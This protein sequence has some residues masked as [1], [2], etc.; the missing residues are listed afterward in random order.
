MTPWLVLPTLIERQPFP[1]RKATRPTLACARPWNVLPAV[2]LPKGNVT[3]N[4]DP[5]NGALLSSLD[6]ALRQ[7]GV[8]TLLDLHAQVVTMLNICVL[9]L[10]LLDISSAFYARWCDTFLLTL[11]KFSLEHHSSPALSL[12]PRMIG[13]TWMSLSAPDSS[14]PSP[15][16]SLTQCSRLPTWRHYPRSVDLHEVLIPREP[17]HPCPLRRPRVPLFLLGRPSHR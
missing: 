4:G 6:A 10:L 3:S 5:N 16:N 11:T 12:L 8:T 17:H 7:Q 9:M 13:Y 15:T 14:A 2:P 1:I